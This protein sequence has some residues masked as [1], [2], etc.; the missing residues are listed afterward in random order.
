MGEEPTILNNRDAVQL[1]T[2][3]F[4]ELV[5]QAGT[6][7]FELMSLDFNDLFI[8]CHSGI[9]THY[10]A[11]GGVYHV[12]SEDLAGFLAGAA[13]DMPEAFGMVREICARNSIEGAPLGF[14]AKVRESL[15]RKRLVIR[16]VTDTKSPSQYLEGMRRAVLLRRSL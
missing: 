2:E 5:T 9:E 13:Q 4:S 14:S 10:T 1:G 6:S 15:D 12:L 11:S 3:Y 8:Q 16:I 7:F